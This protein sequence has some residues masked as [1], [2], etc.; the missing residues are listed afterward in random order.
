MNEI[1]VVPEVG[2]RG[3]ITLAAP[4]NTLISPTTQ[5]TV[6]SVR[7]LRD[8]ISNDVDP[9]TTYYQQ[10]AATTI[11]LSEYQSDLENNLSIVTLISDYGFTVSV[12]C[13]YIAAYPDGNVFKYHNLMVGVSLGAIYEGEDLNALLNQFSAT[14]QAL[15]GVT[16]QIKL[17]SVGEAFYITPDSKVYND[18]ARL[19]V[20]RTAVAGISDVTA[21]NHFTTNA[22]LTPTAYINELVSAIAARDA[23]IA[24]L[25]Q[26]VIDLS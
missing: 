4:F 5:Y 3:L 2:S 18:N 15:I 16:P 1:Y 24:A 10:A 22:T 17:V 19:D 21:N 12:P 20:K 13:R 14:A 9:Y 6:E 23:Q 11:S 25:K 7:T 26:K 8:L